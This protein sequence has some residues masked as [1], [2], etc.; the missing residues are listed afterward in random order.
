MKFG[1][2][3]WNTAITYINQL[4]HKAKVFKT[5][6]KSSEHKLSITASKNP[7]VLELMRDKSGYLSFSWRVNINV[8][9]PFSTSSSLSSLLSGWLQVPNSTERLFKQKT[10]I[11]WLSM[12]RLLNRATEGLWN[13]VEDSKH[14]KSK[15]TSPYKYLPHIVNV[16]IHDP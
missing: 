1:Q 3:D 8:S 11:D 6:F 5:Y 7:I 2:R 12:D 10:R 16:L 15:L 4:M 9:S 13:L 14:Q